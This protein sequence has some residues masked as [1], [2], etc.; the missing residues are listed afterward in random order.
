V[1]SAQRGPPDHFSPW[2]ACGSFIAPLNIGY[3]RCND[4]CDPLITTG[5]SDWRWMT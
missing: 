5:L 1:V 2:A 4:L 3:I